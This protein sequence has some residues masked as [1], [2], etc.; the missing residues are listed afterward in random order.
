MSCARLY[1][2]FG[3]TP[4][5]TAVRIRPERKGNAHGAEQGRPRGRCRSPTD[6]PFLPLNPLLPPVLAPSAK[7]ISYQLALKHHEE[8]YVQTLV[9][10]AA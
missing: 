8:I 1:R 10:L 9:Q 5:R 2:T 7:A 6:I 3:L 4:Q